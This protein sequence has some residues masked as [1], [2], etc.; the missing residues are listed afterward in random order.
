LASDGVQ[1]PAPGAQALWA[2]WLAG[3]LAAYGIAPRLL[4]LLLCG[5]LAMRALRRVRVDPGLPGHAA[6]RDRL[7]PASERLGHDAG[8]PAP[9][10]PRLGPPAAGA[11]GSA[12]LAGVELPAD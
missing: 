10:V 12:V 6:L 4:A 9:A 3:V 11:M 7:C 2:S 5:A 1:A 8:E